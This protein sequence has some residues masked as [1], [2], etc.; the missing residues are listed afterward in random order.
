MRLANGSFGLSP[1][2][3]RRS[4][5]RQFPFCTRE[6][7]F[8]RRFISGCLP[9]L[10]LGPFEACGYINKA[11]KIRVLL[12]RLLLSVIDS[13]LESCINLC[14]CGI[15]ILVSFAALVGGD[16]C[17]SATTDEVRVML[18]A[19]LVALVLHHLS[20]KPIAVT[21]V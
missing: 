9:E 20:Y 13:F 14:S 11:I 16:G 4:L 5:F 15:F 12:S 6:E 1:Q 17:R 10:L 3:E 7:S 19:V 8:V 18:L 21:W 2:I